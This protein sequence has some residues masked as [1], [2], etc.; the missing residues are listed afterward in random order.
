MGLSSDSRGKGDRPSYFYSGES[1]AGQS[2]VDLVTMFSSLEVCLWAWLDPSHYGHPRCS[3]S[4]LGPLQRP[5]LCSPDH[6][7][8]NVT[9]T[10]T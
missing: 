2:Q 6:Q 8:W 3:L 5:P 1:R 4:V 10:S 7:P 9:W